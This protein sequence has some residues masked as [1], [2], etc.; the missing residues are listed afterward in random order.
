[1]NMLGAIVIVLC[2]GGAVGVARILWVLYGPRLAARS[3]RRPR[4]AVPALPA[5]APIVQPQ[6]ASRQPPPVPR[7]RLA[8]GTDSLP[9][10]ASSP[11][12]AVAEE[13]DRVFRAT[14]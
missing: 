4:I 6:L 9:P 5:M 13:T 2:L 3:A 8:R 1:M 11:S 10:Q 7:Q 12:H 14:F